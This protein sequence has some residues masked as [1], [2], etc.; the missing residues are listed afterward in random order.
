M[1]INLVVLKNPFNLQER[2]IKRINISADEMP[3]QD[4]LETYVPVM[5]Q[6]EYHASINGRVFTPEEIPLH[7]VRQ[8]DSVVV[9]PVVSGGGGR[10]SNPL[11]ILAG[12]ALAVFSF[13][14][15]SPF[16]SGLFGG[17]MAGSI[18]GSIAA[19]LT[20]MVGGQ[21]IGNAFSPS[22]SS[23]NKEINETSYGWGSLQNITQQGGIVPITY[24]TVRVAGQILDQRV[25]YQEN[26]EEEILYVLL[27]GGE[28]A[29]DAITDIRI[30]DNPIE[31]YDDATYYTR[32]GENSQSVISGF[33]VTSSSQAVNVTL[34]NGRIDGEIDRNTPGDWHIVEFVG[35]VPEQL[36]VTFNFPRGLCF[37]ASDSPDPKEN[38]VTREVQISFKTN[39]V[40][41][42]WGQTFTY[43]TE[44][45][46]TTPFTVQ[47]TYTAASDMWKYYEAVRVR[48]RVTQ[49]DLHENKQNQCIDTIVWQ[50]LTGA[51]FSNLTHPNKTLVAVKIKATNQLNGGMPT[52]TWKQTRNKVLVYQNGAWV[53]KNALMRTRARS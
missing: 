15:V 21:L 12:L 28:G 26:G 51:N 6:M 42:E 40:W 30:N 10:G 46:D 44:G 53:E 27:S 45:D 33:G 24:G 11:S 4:F 52:I 8:Y 25:D 9:C 5:P 31:N 16:V 50:T 17:G 39:G 36:I 34:E 32:L 18:A 20:L 48:A 35:D 13:G 41:G 2:E 38:W 3:L 22:L 19:G 7:M 49:K 23:E 43:K 47:N 37:Y 14:V 29:I 1:L